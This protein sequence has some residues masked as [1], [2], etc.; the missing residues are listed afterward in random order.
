MGKNEFTGKWRITEMEQWD[1]DFIDAE[2]PGYIS[3]H[4][5]N[6]GEFQFG[7]VH[8]FMDCRYSKGN[9][10]VEF[11]WEGNDEMD[12]ASG[13]GIAVIED[14]NISGHLFF[15]RGDD[16]TFKAIKQ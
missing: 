1:Q 13:R 8:G 10:M 14:G 9:K 3:F 6:M 2:I 12:S 11:S 15:H 7:Y 4:S 16:S 5:D